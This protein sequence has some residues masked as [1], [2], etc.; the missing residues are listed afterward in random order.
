MTAEEFSGLGTVDDQVREALEHVKKEQK[1]FAEM[2]KKLHESFKKKISEE[3]SSSS[4]KKSSK[5]KASNKKAT[6]SAKKD[7]KKEEEAK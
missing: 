7:I 3:A 2:R 1:D 4:S 6:V 5:K